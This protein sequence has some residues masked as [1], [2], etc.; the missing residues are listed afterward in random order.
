LFHFR[1][2][3]TPAVIPAAAAFVLAAAGAASGAPSPSPSPSPAASASPALQEIGS[4][5]TSDRQSEPI[6]KTAKPT[7]VVDR[8]RIDATGARTIADAVADVP[9]VDVFSY[10]A[11]GSQV[12]YGIRGSSSEQTLVLVDGFPITDPTT[13]AVQLGQFSTIGVNR[14][15]IVESGSSTLYGS[16]AA[17]GV[18]N[19]ITSVPRGEYLETSTGSYGD[20]DA[21]VGVGNGYV[22]LTYERHVADNDYGYPAFDYSK[23]ASFEGGVREYAWGDQSAGRLSFNAPAG[24]FTI[25]GSAYL[26]DASIGV[27]GS[28]QYPSTTASQNTSYGTGLVEIER[29]FTSSK[30]TLTYDGSQTR[31]A[32][33]DPVANDGESDVYTGRSQVSLKDVISGH[34]LDTVVGV[35]FSRASGVFTFPAMPQPSAPPLPPSA[36][37]AAQAQS[38]AYVQIAGSPLKNTRFVAGLRGENDSPAGSILAPS[39]GGIINAGVMRFSGNVGESFIVP[40]LNDL[41]YP[42]YSNPNLLPERAQ[43]A[44]VTVAY[45]GR[46]GNVSAGWFDRNGSN[47]IVFTPPLYLPVNAQRAS[48]AGVQL[49]ASTRTFYGMAVEASYTDLYLAYNQSTGARLPQNPVGQT[50]LSLTHPFG[51]GRI[52]WGLNWVVVGS[53][54]DDQANASPV[55]QTF[56]PSATLNAY[57][58]YKIAPHA[59]L[60]VRGFNLANTQYAPIFAYPAPGRRAYVEFSTR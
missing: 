19:I 42:G 10:G 52:A 27:P 54:G 8:A 40:T 36:V 15:E 17:G 28:L 9:G 55:A 16:S 48:T 43:T 21:R 7:Y 35:D 22:G 47:F 23:A 31:L 49:T 4:V 1:F 14:V 32:Y 58:R 11:F 6:D 50:T 57:V 39:F 3:R 12:N 44:D 5:V 2:A 45:Q 29:D 38:A 18:I 41:Y 20:R 30:V 26:A 53:D 24:L 25:R 59:L 37:G 33:I 56:Q 13:G 51:P 46:G 34:L 60:T